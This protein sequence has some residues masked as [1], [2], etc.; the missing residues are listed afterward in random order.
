[1]DE[2]EEIDLQKNPSDTAVPEAEEQTE[3]PWK[4]DLMNEVFQGVQ[5]SVQQLEALSQ[6][7]IQQA[8]R[9]ADNIREE[10]KKNAELMLKESRQ[11]I[12]ESKERIRKKTEQM[13]KDAE[14]E[15]ENILE[16][17]RTEARRLQEETR[18]E[19]S[20]IRREAQ[21]VCE[22]ADAIREE[23]KQN[24]RDI[25]AEGKS[26]LDSLHLILQ[27][28]LEEV[29]TIQ[30]RYKEMMERLSKVPQ[31]ESAV[32]DP[33]SAADSTVTA[34]EIAAT[35]TDIGMTGET[36]Q[37]GTD[38]EVGS[39]ESKE[40]SASA[41]PKK[42]R[43]FGKMFSVMIVCVLTVGVLFQTVW[44]ITIVK[45]DSMSPSLKDGYLVLYSRLDKNMSSGD[46]LVLKQG[47]ASTCLR[48]LIGTEGDVV[49]IDEQTGTVLA[50]NSVVMDEVDKNIY[51]YEDAYTFPLTVQKD[52]YFVLGDNREMTGV[53]EEGLVQQQQVQG[54][55]IQVLKV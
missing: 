13:Q 53:P 5:N 12:E 26:E 7:A 43:K 31:Q 10:A 4:N 52:M 28:Q 23:A 22:E 37:E 49:D 45:G 19:T 18:Q 50:N 20:A 47:K 15:A 30:R 36:G 2:R 11:E 3:V 14:E 25:L 16:Q 42:K 34:E 8:H 54:K 35:P 38:S 55:V 48:R 32:D 27:K 1:M 29:E 39:T 17:A 46:I 51:T 6:K 40:E 24:A 21:Q 44:G 41:K 9:E 33:E